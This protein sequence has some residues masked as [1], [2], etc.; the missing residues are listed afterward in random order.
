[1]SSSL[2]R[3]AAAPFALAATLAAGTAAASQVSPASPLPFEPVNIQMS[4]DSCV[5]NAA[6]VNVV[7]TAE[8][9][10]VR[11]R[12]NAC[13]VAGPQRIVDVR[14][15]AFP[16]GSYRVLL[17]EGTTVVETMR[18]DVL[19]RAEIAVFPPPPHPITDYSGVWW[20]AQES[21]WGLSIHQSARD[22]VFASLFVYGTGRD[23]EWFTF[24]DGS[25]VSATR[26]V[27]T[28]Y[29]TRGPYFGAP[30]Y[31]PAQVTLRSVGAA[32]LDFEQLPS[33]VGKAN[34]RYTVDGEAVEKTIA[35]MGF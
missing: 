30:N 27:G 21:G 12:S 17:V 20:N 35:R 26:W 13:L 33:A 8:G 5:F 10:E 2:Y 11:M 28:V 25:W 16:V 31:D 24:Q 3:F 7:N 14:I 4:V 32:T 34:L 15:G 22:T 18:F 1:M 19:P 9:I 29:R 23:P 6:T